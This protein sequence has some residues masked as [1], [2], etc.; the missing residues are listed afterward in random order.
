MVW[1]Y[2]I[3]VMMENTTSG[4]RLTF[5]MEAIL[6]VFFGMGVFYLPESARWLIS[7]V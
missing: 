5:G 4:W 7:Q 2:A 6:G 3:G 1:G